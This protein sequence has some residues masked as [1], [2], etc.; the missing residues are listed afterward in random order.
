[1]LRKEGEGEDITASTTT[2]QSQLDEEEDKPD[3]HDESEDDSNDSF[4]EFEES[5]V[6]MCDEFR[7]PL[8]PLS[9]VNSKQ[10]AHWERDLRS[11]CK[12]FLELK[13]ARS[14]LVLD[15][16]D[17]KQPDTSE[18]SERSSSYKL[19]LK[20]SREALE[21]TAFKQRSGFLDPSDFICTIEP[22]RDSPY[23]YPR[24][25]WLKPS[26]AKVSDVET[27]SVADFVTAQCKEFVS[28]V[29]PVLKLR[30]I[31]RSVVHVSSRED[32][33]QQ[34][35]VSS[36]PT[37]PNRGDQIEFTFPVLPTEPP[38]ETKQESSSK[39]PLDFKSA[40]QEVTGE[41]LPDVSFML[42]TCLAYPVS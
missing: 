34:K 27:V 31:Y 19:Y 39:K 41:D 40:V 10:S 20:S 21:H 6:L 8:E 42:S 18:T 28:E 22:N 23:N 3:S 36:S 4:G 2:E 17:L 29:W 15:L 12:E 13:E 35:L 37:I 38:E 26:V 1:M 33:L 7:R 11:Y 5:E 24:L 9:I 25:A 14:D 16:S 30:T 32:R